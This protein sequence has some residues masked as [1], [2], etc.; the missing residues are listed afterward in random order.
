MS[1]TWSLNPEDRFS[2]DVSQSI[3]SQN[4]LLISQTREG[5]QKCLGNLHKYCQKWKLVV[6]RDHTKMLCLI[7]S[8][9]PNNCMF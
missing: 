8:R 9:G 7:P 1:L 3:D 4:N 5:L 6:N 2:R